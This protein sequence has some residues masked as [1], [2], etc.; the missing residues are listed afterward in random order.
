MSDSQTSALASQ[1]EKPQ[2]KNKARRLIIRTIMVILSAVV[3]VV[4]LALFLVPNHIMDGGI[5]TV[6]NITSHLLSLPL[7][8]FIF[9]LN[10]PVI[11]LGYKQLGKTHALSIG[12]GITI[13]SVATILLH[14]LDPY[15]KDILLVFGGM[16]LGIGVSIVRSDGTIDDTAILV[17]LYNEKLAL[18]VGKVITIFNLC[19]VVGFVKHTMFSVTQRFKSKIIEGRIFLRSLYVDNQ[20]L[21]LTKKSG[22][23]YGK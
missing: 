9:V 17:N 14:N 8:I 19:M 15:T 22:V 16:I 20:Y 11:F 4:G 3:M 7:G 18:S 5:I 21:V 23:N 12:I 10:L 2:K 1:A 6:S 13:L